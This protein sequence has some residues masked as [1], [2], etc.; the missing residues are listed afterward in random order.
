MARRFDASYRETVTLKGGSQVELRPL[1]PAD[2]ALLAEGFARLSAESRYQ[3]F[4]TGK[5]H[6]SDAEL[7][8]LTDVDGDRHFALCAIGPDGVGVGVARFIRLAAEPDVAELAITVVDSMQRRGLGRILT[9]RLMAAARERGVKMLR[10]E[11]LAENRAMLSI[12]ADKV[13]GRMRNGASVSVDMPV[14]DMPVDEMLR[15]AAERRLS[16]RRA[17]DPQKP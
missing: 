6:L 12:V 9:D 5:E 10:A 4:F 7:N 16:F 8:Y 2:R 3:R 15:L 13:S 17:Y 1:L 14:P 11:I